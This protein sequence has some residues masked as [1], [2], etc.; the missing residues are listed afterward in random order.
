MTGH[1]A[2]TPRDRLKKIRLVQTEIEDLK[3]KGRGYGAA[4]E[5]AWQLAHAHRMML[6]YTAQHVNLETGELTISLEPEEVA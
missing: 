4:S 3:S 2:M 1:L 6:G 5:A